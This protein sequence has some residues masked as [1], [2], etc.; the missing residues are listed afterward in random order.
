[1]SGSAQ[2]NHVILRLDF[3][4]DPAGRLRG[5]R[6]KVLQSDTKGIVVSGQAEPTC[7]ETENICTG[8]IKAYTG[9][10]VVQGRQLLILA[11]TSLSEEA[12]SLMQLSD[13]FQFTVTVPYLTE[14]RQVVKVLKVSSQR[15]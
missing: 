12:L 7:G 1:M 11:T 8:A 14:G 5:N 2:D 6:T 9:F 13:V 15:M 4:S 3:N 10:V